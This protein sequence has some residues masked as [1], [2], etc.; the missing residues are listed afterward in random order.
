MLKAKRNTQFILLS[1]AKS[2]INKSI[3][4]ERIDIN[5]LTKLYFNF[6]AAQK[7]NRNKKTKNIEKMAETLGEKLREAREAKDITIAEVSEQTRISPL[8]L[9][10]IE[11]DDYT[12]LPGGIFNKGFVK[13][14]AKYVGVDENEALQD[15]S[16]LIASQGSSAEDDLKT[17]RPEVLTD[18]N[19]SSSTLT[20]IFFAIVILGAIVVGALALVNYINSNSAENANVAPTPEVNANVSNVNANSNTSSAIPAV[21]TIKVEFAPLS[22]TISVA[23]TVDGKTEN[24]SIKAEETK[25]YTGQQSVKLSYYKGFAGKIRLVVNGKQVTPPSEPENPR[26]VAIEYEINKDN[27]AKFLQEGKITYG[28]NAA[29]NTP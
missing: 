2:I 4:P 21:D 28:E 11:N 7:N 9:D 26:N 1:S 29:S 10:A 25:T 8:Y 14:F 20:T 27:I 5:R 18:E 22:N 19:S 13:S 24:S 15:Y 17:Y 23:S 12:P 3:L 16:R 6:A